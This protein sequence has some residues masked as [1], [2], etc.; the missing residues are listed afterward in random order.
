MKKIGFLLIFLVLTLISGCSNNKLIYAEND[1]WARI[2]SSIEPDVEVKGELVSQTGCI[3]KYTV[4]GNE[5]RRIGADYA[6]YHLYNGEWKLLDKIHKLGLEFAGTSH[7]KPGDSKEVYIDW[8]YVFGR[9]PRGTYKLETRWYTR[10][11]RNGFTVGWIYELPAKGRLK[12]KPYGYTGIDADEVTLTASPISDHLWVLDA[13]DTSQ[14]KWCF[15]FSYALYK[16]EAGKWEEIEQEVKLSPIF[17]G[18]RWSVNNKNNRQ[19]RVCLASVYPSLKP[20]TYRFVKRMLKADNPNINESWSTLPVEEFS[21]ISA[22]FTLNE[23][24]TWS[25]FEAEPIYITDYNPYKPV[26]EDVEMIAENVTAEG[27]ELIVKNNGTSPFSVSYFFNLWRFDAGQW[28][29]LATKRALVDGLMEWTIQP[30]E[31][32]TEK[33]WWG[34]QYGSLE[35]GLY[36]LV[37]KSGTDSEGQQYAVF[38]FKVNNES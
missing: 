33:A 20:G 17:D 12:G 14:E 30:G 29:P 4:T 26:Y 37:A 6:I 32:V 22:E 21:Y 13:K 31:T 3:L 28:L 25:S 11:N 24:L 19:L 7:V 10:W 8:S 36:R 9:L 5:N 27:C 16:M 34:V 18:F 15:D 2:E 1:D 23:K 35:T 38:E